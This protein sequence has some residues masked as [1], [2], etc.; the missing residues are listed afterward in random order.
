MKKLLLTCL[1]ISTPMLAQQTPLEKNNY[2]RLT[3][4][5]ELTQ[6]IYQLDS[7]S[8][9]LKVEV[10]GQSV[11]RRN[12]YALKFSNSIFGKDTS[13]IKVLIFAQQHG[14]EQSGKEGSLL[15][16]SKIIQ[17]NLVGLLKYIDLVLVPQ[18]NPDGSEI[19]VRYNANEMDLNRN[20]L[21][22]TEPEVI[23]LHK[24]FDQYLFE[25]TMDV[26]EYYPYT[27]DYMQYG[28]IKFFDEQIG[29]LTNQN[30]SERIRIF[31]NTEY[32]PFVKAYLN[33]RNFTFHNYIPGGPP[34]INYIRYST[35][36]I[37]DGRQAMGIQNSFSFIQE[38]KNGRDSID[39]IKRRAEGQF[40]GM[41][42]FLGF[43][44][45]HK[46][47]IKTLVSEERSKLISGE[48]SDSFAIQMEHVSNGEKLI[49]SL[50]SI[51]TNTDS[52]ITVTDFRPVVKSIYNVERPIGYLIPKIITELYDWA[53]RQ[54]LIISDFDFTQDKII[55]QYF[56]N[57]I[58][59]IDFEGDTIVNPIVQLNIVSYPIQA[60]DYYFIPT[61]QLK[62]NL[63]V[64]ALEPKSILGL[65]TY[66]QYANLLKA[67]DFFSVLRVIS[68]KK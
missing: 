52:L 61:N 60:S 63:I 56:V 25:A 15:L 53:V 32:L 2:E 7:L 42:G 28:Y 11:E 68:Q 46:S 14:D 41:L 64:T 59:S 24:L 39:N 23:A 34:E 8:D 30:V 18:M 10:L 29:T 45:E 19:N 48:V 58:E 4:Y 16:A 20:H 44:S 36:D 66:K 54:N 6:Y 31:S 21:I 5:E 57:E 40:Q 65:V 50:R 47:K 51:Y 17:P 1:L 35:Y 13:K 67:G 3:S 22:L 9:N 55:Q 38:G 43:C 33:E 49:V 37:N 62:N 12:L 26:H 27:E